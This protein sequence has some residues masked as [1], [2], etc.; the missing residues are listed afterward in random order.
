MRIAGFTKI[1]AVLENNKL[2]LKGKSSLYLKYQ[3]LID[4][5]ENLLVKTQSRKLLFRKFAKL[6]LSY[7]AVWI[8]GVK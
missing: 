1:Y 2:G 7:P 8:V 5:L 3:I 4:H 6:M